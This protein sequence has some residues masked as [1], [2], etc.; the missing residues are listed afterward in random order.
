MN[1]SIV[2]FALNAF[3]R[4]GLSPSVLAHVSVSEV[5]FEVTASPLTLPQIS[6]PG[7]CAPGSS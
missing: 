6:S 3:F 4:T 5:A 1:E 7:G 2:S